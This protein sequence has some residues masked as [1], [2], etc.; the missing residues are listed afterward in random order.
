MQW[1][2]LLP[3]QPD[4]PIYIPLLMTRRALISCWISSNLW[5]PLLGDKVPF[6][7]LLFV[8]Q[9]AI[10]GEGLRRRWRPIR[11]TL[12][13]GTREKERQESLGVQCG[14][15]LGKQIE[16]LHESWF[17][18][19]RRDRLSVAISV[20]VL[21]SHWFWKLIHFFFFIIINIGSWCSNWY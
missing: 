4:H 8:P 15:L 6:A 14:F 21:V 13:V 11:P 5:K 18:M 10:E 3:C 7:L 9:W 2:S 17:K 19:I 12:C 16:K 1:C 20:V